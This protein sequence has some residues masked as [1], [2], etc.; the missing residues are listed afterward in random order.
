[1]ISPYHYAL[2]Y[3]HLRV[4]LDSG[5]HVVVQV[6][7]YQNP[8]P[9][10]IVKPVPGSVWWAVEQKLASH[11]KHEGNMLNGH[12]IPFCANW[13]TSIQLVHKGG[14]TVEEIRTVL[15]LVYCYWKDLR[16]NCSSSTPDLQAYVN[17]YIGLY[18]SG[19]VG[20]YASEALGCSKKAP[21]VNRDILQ[22]F[23]P[24]SGRRCEVEDVKARD[25][26]V[27]TN[28]AHVAVIDH[29]GG[30]RGDRKARV[31]ESSLDGGYRGLT[32]SEY[33]IHAAK[34]K[35]SAPDVFLVTRGLPC[36]RPKVE[37]FIAS[38][39]A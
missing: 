24:A 36:A 23:A 11:I 10:Y 29:I 35:P 37:V 18:C 9:N 27:W 22:K 26:I 1:M 6:R 20:A 38:P 12:K 5:K 13:P 39:Y 4:P 19:F 8:G 2:D 3:L 31:I 28:G 33:K 34:P 16:G 17:Q 7:D 15:G 32:V 25:V 14:G 21:G 30:L